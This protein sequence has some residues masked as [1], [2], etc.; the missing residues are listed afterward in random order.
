M[1]G[2][3]LLKSMEVETPNSSLGGRLKHELTLYYTRSN[4]V[5]ASLER[6]C[7][8]LTAM[9]LLRIG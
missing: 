3:P 2:S 6:H 8:T 5:C 4:E 1:L 7:L 9:P